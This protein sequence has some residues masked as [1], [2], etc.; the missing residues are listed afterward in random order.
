[1]DTM[2]VLRPNEALQKRDAVL[3]ACQPTLRIRDRALSLGVKEVSLVA[4]DCGLTSIELS[5][6]YKD[7]IAE[8]PSL[9]EVM[10]LSRNAWCVHERHGC[11]EHIDTN[12]HVGLVLGKDIDLRL[13]LSQW[14]GAY[15]VD[16]AGRLSLQF[17]DRAGD[18]I[19]KVYAT[20]KTD[21]VAFSAL[22]QRFSRTEK[23]EPLLAV[24]KPCAYETTASDPE[25]VRKHWLALQDTHDFYPMLQRFKLFRLGALQAVGSD[26]AQ[27]VDNGTVTHVLK[28]AA[29]MQLAIM[30]FVDNRGIVQIHSGPI[31]QLR[32]T[33]RWFNV[34]DKR[35][36]LHLDT[37]AINSVWVVNK[38]T[39]DGW[40][41]SLEVYTVNGDLIVQFF[42]ARKPGIPEQPLWRKLMQGVCDEPLAN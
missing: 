40:V 17:F 30:C 35:F 5:G 13:F 21:L 39:C 1:M 27:Q 24:I 31:C 15:A 20:E 14:A 25:A 23:G 32:R 33:G 34:L 22:V 37:E 18:A 6:A 19:H 42:G 8:L 12:G 7:I 36:N 26:L 3:R 38:P 2:I 9:G 11:Y 28:L 16:C 10:A 41:T 4:A 29:A